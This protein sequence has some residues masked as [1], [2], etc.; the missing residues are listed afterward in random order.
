MTQLTADA[1]PVIIKFP[2]VSPAQ[3]K[4]AILLTCYMTG[5]PAGKNLGRAGYSYDFVARLYMPL[6]ER[7]GEVIPVPQPH[8]NLESAIAAA[9]KRG[10]E[11]LH[12]SILPFQDVCLAQT[13]PNVVVPA[14]EFPDIPNEA[15]D[16]NPQNDWPATANRCAMTLVGGPFTEDALRRAGTTTPIRVVQVPTPDAYFHI[17]PWQAGQR[18]Q[19]GGRPFVFPQPGAEPAGAP[20]GKKR[21]KPWK[22]LGKALE[23]SFRGFWKGFLGPEQYKEYSLSM[24]R[25]RG[26]R[27]P[28]PRAERLELDGIVYTSIFNPSDGRKNWEDLLSGFL[29]ALNDCADATLVVKL[30][31]G[32][33]RVIEDF[34]EF[35]LEMGIRHR[36]RLVVLPDFLSDEQMLDLAAASTYYVQSTKAEGN[37][38]PLMNYLAAGRPGISPRHSAMLDYFDAEVG[39][40]VESHPEPAIWPHDPSLRT[41]TTRGRIVWTSL[42][43]QYRRSYSLAKHDQRGYRALADRGRARMAAW[44]SER[45]VGLRLAAALDEVFTAGLTQTQREATPAIAASARRAA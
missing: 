4:R 14:W 1:E 38:L 7:C 9:R 45:Q 5:A 12:F 19:I 24:A 8:R 36:C 32:N 2:R 42:V 15:F 29:V 21:F 23:G 35:Y 3:S 18:R 22:R 11:P 10:L 16:N 25:R 40:E 26:I 37:C 31:N 44:V 17:E 39:F 34:V 13:A 30:I 33:P 27:L 41:R 6:L 28:F 20:T 43:E